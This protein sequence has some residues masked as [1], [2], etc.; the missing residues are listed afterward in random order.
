M[1]TAQNPR[2]HDTE[3]CSVTHEKRKKVHKPLFNVFTL[4]PTHLY[5]HSEWHSG[6]WH[7]KL[8]GNEVF[9]LRSRSYGVWRA[10]GGGRL[11]HPIVFQ[12]SQKFTQ[13]KF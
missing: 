11:L 10:A 13:Q 1:S 7:S 6:I 3:T 2:L 9:V 8:R 5:L 4:F 12:N